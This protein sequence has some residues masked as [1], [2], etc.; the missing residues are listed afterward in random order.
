[1]NSTHESGKPTASHSSLRRSPSSP[2]SEL[3]QQ[4]A[5]LAALELQCAERELELITQVSELRQFEQDYFQTI[6]K[7]CVELDRAEA[8]LAEYLAHLHPKDLR[9]RQRAQQAWTKAQETEAA[10]RELP[11]EGVV[12]F[13]PSEGLKK[14]YRE[15]AKRIHP[16]LVTDEAER[17][18]RLELMIAANR[19]YEQGNPE[20]LEAILAGWEDT[21]GWEQSETPDAQLLRTRRQIEQIQL[22][23]VAIASELSEL[24]NSALAQLHAQALEV[25]AQGRDL[26]AELAFQLDEEIAAIERHTQEIKSKLAL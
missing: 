6:G 1:M 26:L 15:V 23:L 20:V 9:L 24:Q 2:Q 16:D 8:Q 5:I 19:A 22:R 13:R 7:R 18:R 21:Q 4:Q 12:H 11:L 17:Q 3:E 25:Q 10:N 14:L